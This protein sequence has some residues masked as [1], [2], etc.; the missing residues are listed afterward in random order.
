[1][2]LLNMLLLHPSAQSFSDNIIAVTGSNSGAKLRILFE[3]RKMFQTLFVVQVF[4]L[5][6]LL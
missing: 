6:I 1:M 3:N 2:T 4:F 5:S